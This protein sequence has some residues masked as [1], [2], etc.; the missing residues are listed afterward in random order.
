MK[1]SN[2]NEIFSKDGKV[3]IIFLG[4]DTKQVLELVGNKI[5]DDKEIVNAKGE[6]ETSFFDEEIIKK[7]HLGGVVS[8]SKIFI[9]NNLGSLYDYLESKR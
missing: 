9:R 4:K 2:W 7:K 1:E 3:K 8:G 5:N 6:Q